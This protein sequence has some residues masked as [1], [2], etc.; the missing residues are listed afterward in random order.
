LVLNKTNFPYAHKILES[1]ETTVISLGSFS[2]SEYEQF[3]NNLINDLPGSPQIVP[4][5]DGT[6]PSLAW[7]SYLVFV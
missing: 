7:N 3:L 1:L 4:A 6:Q 5:V 2:F